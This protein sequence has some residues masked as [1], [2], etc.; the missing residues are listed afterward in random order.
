[1]IA[2]K[3]LKHTL[4]NIKYFNFK[5]RSL[6][7]YHYKNIVDYKLISIDLIL[8]SAS[9]LFFK[10]EITDLLKFLLYY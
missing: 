1:M 5:E 9:I 6:H 7:S 2:I 10:H 3:Q 8:I 4:R